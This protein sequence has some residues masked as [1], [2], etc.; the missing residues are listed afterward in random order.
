R[1]RFWEIFSSVLSKAS[2]TLNYPE[3]IHPFTGGG[4]MGD[5]HHGWVAAEIISAIRDAFIFEN[6]DEDEAVLLQGIP[7]EWFEVSN[8]FS[9]SN[10]PLT[11][12]TI[13]IFIESSEGKIIIKID[14]KKNHNLD[15]AW[16][17]KIKLPVQISE[18]RDGEEIISFQPH[19]DYSEITVSPA[20]STLTF[21]KAEIPRHL[22]KST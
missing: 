19:D 8:K 10:S 17:W 1:K 15:S 2:P 3:A 9:L 12:G 14:F 11:S 5:G 4:V 20:S 21:I 22:I 6:A 18:A 13:S 7:A 16:K